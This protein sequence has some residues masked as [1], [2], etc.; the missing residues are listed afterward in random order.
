[1]AKKTSRVHLGALPGYSLGWSATAAE[2]DE[3][4]VEPMK[5]ELKSQ[6]FL[7][8]NESVEVVVRKVEQILNEVELLTIF[9]SE[10]GSSLFY[11]FIH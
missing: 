1:M 11:T 9:L 10:K 4:P 5:Q 2:P 8:L 3:V 7:N 6:V